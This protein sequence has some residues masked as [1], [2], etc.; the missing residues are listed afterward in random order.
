MKAAYSSLVVQLVTLV[1]VALVFPVSSALSATAVQACGQTYSGD[2]FLAGD[3]DCSAQLNTG[4]IGIEGGLLD[5]AGFTFTGEVH[6]TGDCRI[7]SSG[8]PGHIVAGGII[9]RGPG[10]DLSLSAL[11]VSN[12]EM[13][14]SGIEMAGNLRMS[15]V[16][17]VNG[18]VYVGAIFSEGRGYSGGNARIERSTIRGGGVATRGAIA[19][20]YSEVSGAGGNGIDAT[21]GAKVER[22]LIVDNTANGILSSGDFYSPGRAVQLTDSTVERNGRGIYAGAGTVKISGSSVSDNADAGI[23]HL[24]KNTKVSDSTVLNNGGHGVESWKATK[25]QR[26]TIQGN[27]RDGVHVRDTAPDRPG[28]ALSDATVVGNGLSAEC[29]TE[30]CADIVVGERPRVVRTTCESSY[31]L[32][33]MPAEDWDICSLD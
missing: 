8:T 31:R 13:H 33:S 28:L 27:G 25:I 3:L 9:A 10:F 32:E 16:V 23:L 6:C 2:G 5:L 30:T 26:T 19:I 24:G 29:A 11:Q 20:E 12:I 14:D 18:S 22:C 21:K 4:F 7:E 1:S 15:G 17:V